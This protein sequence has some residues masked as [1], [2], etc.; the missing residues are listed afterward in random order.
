M[1]VRCHIRCPRRRVRL[2]WLPLLLL[3]AGCASRVP[4]NQVTRWPPPVPPSAPAVFPAYELRRHGDL[5][6]GVPASGAGATALDGNCICLLGHDGAVYALSPSEPLV[7]GWAVRFRPDRVETLPAGSGRQDLELLTGRRVPDAA[8]VCVLRLAGRFETIRLESAGGRAAEGPV[9]RRVSGMVFGLREPPA[10]AG[11]G[12]RH[13]LWFLSH[14]LLTGGRV[15]DFRLIDGSL[16]I[17]LCSRCLIVNA[18]ADRAL[19]QL[20]E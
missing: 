17:D 7:S 4:C 16:A 15:A 3:P 19:R 11:G 9:L 6:A 5:G 13:E 10:A 20:R 8:V 1:T 2:A 18:A 14:D 12:P